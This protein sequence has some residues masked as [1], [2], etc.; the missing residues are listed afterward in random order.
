MTEPPETL[1]LPVKC[2]CT[3]H[4]SNMV[5]ERP[6]QYRDTVN[7]QIKYREVERINVPLYQT[8]DNLWKNS[9]LLLTCHL[10]SVM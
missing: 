5:I 6:Q 3:E 4:F 8:N 2:I 7:K 9:A 10:L 1:L